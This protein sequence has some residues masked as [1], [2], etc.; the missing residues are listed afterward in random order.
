ML[1]IAFK[2]NFMW[3]RIHSPITSKRYLLRAICTFYLRVPVLVPCWLATITRSPSFRG[4]PDIDAKEVVD[5]AGEGVVDLF[6]L[7]I[8][9]DGEMEA[10]ALDANV[11]LEATAGNGVSVRGCWG[12]R[13]NLEGFENT[14][15]IGVHWKKGEKYSNLRRIGWRKRLKTHSGFFRSLE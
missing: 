4:P 1:K 10:L 14:P 8:L 5:P 12:C 11:V 9:V 6:N 2:V 15:C 13:L 3:M 7:G